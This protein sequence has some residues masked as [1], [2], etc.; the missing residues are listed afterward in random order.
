MPCQAPS[1]RSARVT[2]IKQAPR[3][4]PASTGDYQ[5]QNAVSSASEMQLLAELNK[6]RRERIRQTTKTNDSE[7][8]ADLTEKQ[9]FC[10]A[11][12]CKRE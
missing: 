2:N 4:V 9:V 7:F 12:G 8:D 10:T 3:S 1:L 6:R 5:A 11:E